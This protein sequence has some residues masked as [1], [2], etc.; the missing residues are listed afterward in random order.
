MHRQTE[1]VNLR[2][3]TGNSRGRNLR[4][5]NTVTFSNPKGEQGQPKE[6]LMENIPKT[7]KGTH[8]EK[9]GEERARER[10]GTPG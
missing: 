3:R 10:R 1:G 9:S 5:R 7:L 2:K 6:E 4:W 8:Q